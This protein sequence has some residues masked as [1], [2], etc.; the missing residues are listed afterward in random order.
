MR[1]TMPLQYFISLKNNVD[2]VLSFQPRLGEIGLSSCCHFYG[3]NLSELDCPSRWT[4]TINT[5][6]RTHARARTR[7]H[8]CKKIFFTMG[9]HKTACEFSAYP[10]F[11]SSQRTHRQLFHKETTKE[12]N[13]LSFRLSPVLYAHFLKVTDGVAC[14]WF[15]SCRRSITLCLKSFNT[16]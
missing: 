13:R 15:R 6:A 8:T 14:Y 9:Q 5:H 7:T 3:V 4:V 1:S 11:Q 12:M 16:L 10:H 2:T